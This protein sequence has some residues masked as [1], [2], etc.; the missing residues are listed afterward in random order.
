MLLCLPTYFSSARFFFSHFPLKNQS[1]KNQR[2]CAE[3]ENTI[4]TLETSLAERNA[5]IRIL[6]SKT[7][8]SAL[9]NPLTSGIGLGVTSLP[10]AGTSNNIDDIIAAASK[11]SG[12]DNVLNIPI[13]GHHG[14]PHKKQFSTPSLLSSSTPTVPSNAHGLVPPGPVS[15]A[16]PHHFHSLAPANVSLSTVK[17][18]QAHRSLTPS[19]DMFLRGGAG[20]ASHHADALRSATPSADFLRAAATPT[21]AEILKQTQDLL[22][23]GAGQPPTSGDFL[24]AS[25]HGQQ[26][27]TAD[28]LRSSAQPGSAEAVLRATPT[29]AVSAEL[30]SRVSQADF[31]R[32]SQADLLRSQAELL[33]R[34]GIPTSGAL[35]SG[36]DATNMKRREP[37]GQ[38]GDTAYHHPPHPGST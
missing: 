28:L 20:P 9:N 14:S 23:A 17:K 30:M 11:I 7:T 16:T 3:M 35:P 15:S 4:K 19:A 24:R 8:T 1:N 38:A 12:Q 6:Q 33:S 13:P 26:L 27:T 31:M 32:V 29:A 21:N 5:A 2:K 36:L 34:G 18:L 10:P 22:R 25:G 37:S